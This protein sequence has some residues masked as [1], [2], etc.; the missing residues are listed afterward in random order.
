MCITGLLEYA[1][2]IKN[3]VFFYSSGSIFYMA[4]DESII[5]TYCCSYSGMNET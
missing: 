1:Q 5:V 3:S 4:A 2:Q